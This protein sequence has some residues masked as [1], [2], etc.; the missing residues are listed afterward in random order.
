MARGSDAFFRAAPLCLALALATSVG[1]GH[2]PAHRPPPHKPP[3]PPPRRP[4]LNLVF[5]SF[6]STSTYHKINKR[7]AKRA[8]HSAHYVVSQP[9]LTLRKTI[10]ERVSGKNIS[11][12]RMV[13]PD[14]EY[15]MN[16]FFNETACYKFPL[17]KQGKDE[18]VWED[19]INNELFGRWYAFTSYGGKQKHPHCPSAGCDVWRYNHNGPAPPP[20]LS[21]TVPPHKP[22][23]HKPPPHKPPPPPP[24]PPRVTQKEWGTYWLNGADVVRIIHRTSTVEHG[25][26]FTYTSIS[27]STTAFT[28]YTKPL[29][30][31]FQPTE[32]CADMVGPGGPAP[33]D[34]SP[35]LPEAGAWVPGFRHHLPEGMGSAP[36]Y[37]PLRPPAQLFEAVNS[38]ARIAEVNAQDLG[39]RAAPAPRFDEMTLHEIL[40]VRPSPLARLTSDLL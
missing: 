31:D 36:E 8:S 30:T 32:H 39:W 7:P 29:S 2:P 21:E 1:G 9:K 12:I 34:L 14:L 40:P 35:A 18:D 25:P 17:N 20:P 27:N 5:A 6:V 23:P 22:P 16:P 13:K 28:P 15:R 10:H 11:R 19:L 33:E 3:P 26:N 4:A 38:R 37:L 24:P